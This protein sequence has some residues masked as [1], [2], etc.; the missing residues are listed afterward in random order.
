MA[1][2]PNVPGQL[3]VHR[4]QLHR[5]VSTVLSAAGAA[6]PAA[7]ACASLPWTLALAAEPHG[8]PGGVPVQSLGG[9]QQPL[10]QQRTSGDRGSRALRLVVYE[11]CLAWVRLQV[12]LRL[13]RSKDARVPGGSLGRS[14]QGNIR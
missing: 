7:A 11:E 1:R 14:Y 10:L 8:L 12:R 9:Q 5:L 13:R 2:Q 6:A 3:H 4:M